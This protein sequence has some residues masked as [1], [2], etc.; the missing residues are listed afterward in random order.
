MTKQ[1]TIERVNKV[2]MSVLKS[3]NQGVERAALW[4]RLQNLKSSLCK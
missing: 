3:P 4:F 1:I 2:I